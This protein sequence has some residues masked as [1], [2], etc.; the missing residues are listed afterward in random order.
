LE[1]LVLRVGRIA[2]DLPEVRSLSLDP[3]L[4]SAAGTSVAGA[5][6]VL[7]PPPSREDDGPRRLR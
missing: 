1:E 5:R 3:V 6:I 4:T 7:G 2:E